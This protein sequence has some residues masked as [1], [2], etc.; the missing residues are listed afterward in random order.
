MSKDKKQLNLFNL[1]SLGV[2]GAI[3]S[4]I[5]VM[6]G[7]GIGMTGRSISIALLIG[8]L[9]MMCSY[10]YNIFLSSMFK[11]DGGAYSQQAFLCPPIISGVA[12]LNNFILSLALAMYAVSMVE[13]A[14]SIFIAIA[15]Y[16]KIIAI[17]I[18][19]L[20]FAT[21]LK[22]AK[23]MSTIQGI[24]V[25]ILF[26]SMGLFVVVG[27][28]QVDPNFFTGE[29]FFL[30]GKTGFFSAVSI[31]AFA[32]QGTTNAISMASVS[33]NPKRNIPLSIILTTAIIAVIYCSM[34]IVA[35]GVLPVEQVAGKSLNVVAEAMFPRPVYVIFILG[36]AVFAI[37]TSLL[38]SITMLQY[39]LVATAEDG[40]L[41]KFIG[42]KTN[43]GYPYVVML[44]LYLFAVVPIITGTGVDTLVSYVMIPTMVI[45]GLC[46]F[47]MIKI[48]K[49]YPEQWKESILHMPYP[50]YVTL[51]IVSIL[52]DAF[53]A[54]NLFNN[55]SSVDR[56][57]VPI[58]TIGL[59]AISYFRLKGGYVNMKSIEDAKKE[60]KKE[61]TAE[62]A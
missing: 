53:V 28:P 17:L 50:I 57:L 61:A 40:W 8:C 25:V 56:I 47:Y 55:L 18:Q 46:N 45:C 22:G 1:I 5:F 9:I 32:C 30:N 41:P 34:S 44:I 37:A 20:F 21:S 35:A 14:S 38:G 2:G 3:G 13:Y 49:K 52:C 4:G 15:P 11:L 31:M 7:S 23:F 26:I 54:Y 19:T 43:G 24:M 59:F 48:P 16:K 42:K 29:G 12:A 62:I 10:S 58:V 51:M 6:M 33:K 39:P 60:A 36:G 27:I